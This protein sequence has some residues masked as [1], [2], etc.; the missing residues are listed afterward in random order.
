MW[1][2]WSSNKIPRHLP[3]SEGPYV[4]G[5][6]D[7]MTDYSP[8]G[9]FVRLHYPTSLSQVKN[10]SNRWIP[11]LPHR[12]YLEGFAYV[13][14]LWTILIKFIIYLFS[15]K[16]YI[17]IVWGE[18]LQKTD[19]KLPVIVFSHGLG[20][21]RFFYSILCAELASHGFVVAA[22]EHR[23]SSACTS[24]YYKSSEDKEK[25]KPTWIP[26]KRV[27]LGPNHYAAREQQIRARAMECRRTVDLLEKLNVGTPVENVLGCDFELSQFKDRLDLSN[28][29]MMGH[30]FGGATAL[31]TLAKDSRFKVGVILDGWMFPLKEETDLPD[32]VQLP[33]LFVNTQ[34]FP[35]PSNVAIMKKFVENAPIHHER[36]VYTIRLT[37]HENQ[38]DTPYLIGYWLNFFMKKLDPV[39]GTRINHHLIIRFLDKHVGVPSGGVQDTF[40]QNQ[41]H[42][43]VQ[44]LSI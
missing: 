11:W 8:D 26:F 23:D 30:S 4:P 33:L 43:I 35:I 39:I 3:V 6:F 5:C 24:F 18:P 13:L 27:P 44:A 20:A 25:L 16:M 29:T 42:N 36:E 10:H 31:F 28:L 17:P 22:L 12:R 19:K 40:L 34:T 21:T 37:T 7:L 38:T 15:G 14:N 32:K 1:W 41:A 2:I 9:C